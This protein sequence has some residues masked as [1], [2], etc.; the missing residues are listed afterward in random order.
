M[1]LTAIDGG[2]RWLKGESEVAV[3]ID[4]GSQE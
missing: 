1:A 4:D 3:G 2:G